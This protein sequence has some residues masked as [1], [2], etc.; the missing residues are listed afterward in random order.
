MSKT[1]NIEPINQELPSEYADRLGIYYTQQVT[2][3]HKKDNGQFFT[4]TSIARLM[5]SYCDFTKSKI[6]IL[7]PGCGTAI[8]TCALIEHLV[9]TRNDIELIELVA[10]ETDPDLISFSQKA[11]TYL[12]SWLL[13][14]GIRLQY[15]LHIHD[16]ILDNA[17]ALKQNY[18]GEQFDLIIS[19]PP[20]FKL[21]KDDEKTIAAKELV[22]GQP[23]IYSIFMGIAAKLL[24]GNGELIFITPRSFA[25]GNYFK[26]FRELFFNTVQI[27]KIHL[28]NSRK[29]T[30]SRDSVLQ[31]T[32]VIKAIRETIDPNKNVLV[33][34]S[35]G[36]KDIFEPTIK[37]F[38]SSELI[39]LN[40]KEKILHLPTSDKEESILNLVSTWK[41]VL[42]D[43]NIKISTGPV[44]SFRALNFI[45]S[46]YQNRTVFLA[47]LFW[48]HNVNKMIL[49]WPKQLKDKGQFIRI[50]NGSKSLLIPNKNYILLR[51]FSTKDDKSRLIAAPYFCNY[52]KSDFIGVENKVNYIYRKDGH[53]DRNEMVGIC[54]I[55]NSE[56]FDNYFQIFNGN[57][58][59]SATELREMKFPP[60]NDIKKIG[61]KII[62]S[63]DY[64]MTNVNNIVNELFELEVIMN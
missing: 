5:A 57:V 63:N 48:L 33:S 8:L 29:D 18:N 56:L 43:F 61:Y 46:N 55:L 28:F 37:H 34:S 32:V 44:V 51:R 39:D 15:L 40:S 4:P 58:N 12:K 38:N 60:L 11:L 19:N 20:Y 6:R 24:S 27:D 41:N 35:I 62:L 54:A 21:A 13:G 59:V 50:E 14:K 3:R 42:L 26:A 9:E 16:F 25:S 45:Q 52:V 36:I 53:L 1:I 7:D 49:E 31:E 30:F 64:S 22:S 17:E 23:N 2:T 10:Y 47:P